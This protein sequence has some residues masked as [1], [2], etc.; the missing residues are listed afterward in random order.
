MIKHT[1]QDRV[2]ARNKFFNQSGK[3]GRKNMLR[4]S[5]DALIGN[6]NNSNFT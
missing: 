3:A 5:V 4:N 1:T 6:S 2:I